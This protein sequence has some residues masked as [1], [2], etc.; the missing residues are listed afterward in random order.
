MVGGRDYGASQFNRATDAMRQPGSSFKP[1]VYAAALE[2]GFKPTSIVVDAPICLGNWCPHN[3]GRSYRGSMTLLQALTHSINTIA[4]RLSVSIGDGNAKLG[5][6]RII[7]LAHEMGIVTPLP[8]T[9]SLPIGADAVTLV[10]HVGAYGTFPNLGKRV[11]PHAILEVRTG[12]GHVVWRFDRDGPKPKQVLSVSAA[13]GMITMMNNVVE[14]G[15]ARRARLDGIA[16]AGKTG[17]TNAYRDAWFMGYTGNFVGGVWFGNDDYTS[18]NRMTGGSLPA[19]TWQAMMSYAHQGVELKPLP[20]I[21]APTDRKLPATAQAKTPSTEPPPPPRTVM[22]TKRG[23]DI[24]VQLERLMDE[25]HRALPAPSTPL[26]D[27]RQ[28]RVQASRQA[29]ER[30]DALAAALEGRALE[31]N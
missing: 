16:A 27:A 28:R 20:G 12:D 10:E 3:Y 8:D 19:M 24:L 14:N 6:S 15:T 4:V 7:K 2:H 31:R 25:A 9:P 13:Q 18:T 1:Y 30:G 11:S 26:S 5:R 17:T 23:V 22:L 29:P 21:P